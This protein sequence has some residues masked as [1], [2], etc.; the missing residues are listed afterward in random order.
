VILVSAIMPTRGRQAWAHQALE[1]F[2]AQTYPEKELIILDD[3]EE[4]SFPE[5]RRYSN[6]R[7]FWESS[8]PIPCKR[9]RAI[10]LSSGDIIMHFD[11]DDWSS[12]ERMADQVE[13]LEVSGKAVTGY[14]SMLFK[15]EPSGQ[16]IQYVG[17][18]SYALGTSLCYRR[19]FWKDHYFR[20]GPEHP[21]VGEDNEF[22]KDAR[23]AG[24][25]ISVPAG[26]MMWARIHDQ[27]TSVKRF[28]NNLQYRPVLRDAV[29]SGF[30]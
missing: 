20:S 27:N 21:N 23:Q 15:I 7:Y 2:L 11:S 12:P 30:R 3:D 17:D 6:V 4:R 26:A 1:C 19:S 9:N 24:E 25:L 29:P 14:H 18:S 5:P 28:D 8:K 10:E 16:W 13:R 22:V